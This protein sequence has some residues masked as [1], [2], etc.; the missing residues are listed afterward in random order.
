MVEQKSSGT[1]AQVAETLARSFRGKRVLLTGGLGFIGSSLALRLL[2]L[3]ASVTVLD[4]LIP[5]YG[6]NP[7][8]LHPH[9]DQFQIIQANVTQARIVNDLVQGQDFI[10]HCAGQVSHV[11]GLRDPYPDL[12]YTIKG[13]AV[14]MEAC[15]HN[16]LAA[17]V[18]K[19]GTRGQYGPV[20]KLPVGEE[21][22]S[23]P[24]GIY[25]I[26]NLAAEKIMKVYH[27]VHGMACVLLRLTNIYGPRSQMKSHHF[28]VANW[29]IRQAMEG[30]TI[31]VFGDGSTLR[32][33]LYIDDCV[34]AMLLCAI[35]P[36]AR[37]EVINLG[38]GQPVSLLELVKLII[39]AVGKGQWEFAEFSAE[40]KASEP[41]DF[42]A[43][44]SKLRRLVGWEPSVGLAEG[45][46]AT[47]D[48]YRKYRQHYW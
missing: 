35:C 12:E 41:G 42:Y 29:F 10:F 30:Q 17:K 4:A 1:E 27:D 20:Q 8:N 25:E 44:I 46:A 14:L 23:N 34:Q 16:N 3:G 43:D 32:D 47:V 36:E 33:F 31:R 11:L 18:I 15:R 24:R 7:F 6:G 26:S 48:Y 28:G 39:A 22:P 45:L 40:R 37:G 9:Y 38:N 5:D 2:D 13:T 19:T 21:A